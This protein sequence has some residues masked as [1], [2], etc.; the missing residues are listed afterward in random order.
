[1]IIKDFAGD[2]VNFVL[3]T[4]GRLTELHTVAAEDFDLRVEMGDKTFE[5]AELLSWCGKEGVTLE[6]V[7]NSN[8]GILKQ[9]AVTLDATSLCYIGGGD[10][11]RWVR[12]E[13]KSEH[14]YPTQIDAYMGACL[15]ALLKHESEQDA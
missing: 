15:E 10:E 3:N 12:G 7:P 2:R 1:M 8:E 11:Y 5:L 6:T 9:M 14:T 13:E 4:T